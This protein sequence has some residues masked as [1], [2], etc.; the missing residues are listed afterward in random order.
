MSAQDPVITPGRRPP[1]WRLRVPL[2]PLAV[3]YILIVAM[4]AA[5]FWAMDRQDQAR[6]EDLV[7]GRQVLRDLVELTDDN[8]GGLHLTA[9]PGFDDL[10]PETQRYMAN[11]EAA[12]RT[13]PGE[14]DRPSRF[15]TEALELLEVPTCD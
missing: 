15:V 5:G 13:D 2:G 14:P 9:V 11:I 12:T 6:C 8:G 4:A 1:W 7:A 10:P 3:A